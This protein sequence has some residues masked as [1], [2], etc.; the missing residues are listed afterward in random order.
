MSSTPIYLAILLAVA[1][2]FAADKPTRPQVVRV[3]EQIR[4]ADYE[5]DRAALLRLH[6][7]L[8]PPDGDAKL[9]SRVRYWRGF[10]LWRRVFNGFN[11]N[12]AMAELEADAARALTEF[13][14]AAARDPSFVDA[15]VGE[16]SCLSIL[17]FIHR[18]EPAR[19]KE[20][21]TRGQ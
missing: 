17:T 21:K 12:V 3:V 7:E 6:D 8:T 20:F 5:G 1:P 19:A 18:S 11:D 2:A 15:R 13:D 10:A 9:A 14:E 4:K 16:I